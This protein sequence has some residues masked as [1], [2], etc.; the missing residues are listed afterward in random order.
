[1][2]LIRE[3]QACGMQRCMKSSLTWRAERQCRQWTSLQ[4]RPGL[5]QGLSAVK[6]VSGAYPAGSDSLAHSNMTRMLRE[7]G[8]PQMGSRSPLAAKVAQRSAF[9]TVGTATSSSTSRPPHPGSGQSLHLRGPVTVNKFFLF[10]TTTESSLLL[11]QRDP[12]SLNR[13]FSMARAVSL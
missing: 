9:L 8:S 10:R 4:I 1:M 2:G 7:L 5:P 11:C 13:R 3:A 6:R 12:S